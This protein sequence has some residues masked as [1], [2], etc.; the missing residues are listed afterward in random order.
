MAEKITTEDVEKIAQ[1]A[2]L[3]LS[4][5][6]IKQSTEDLQNV[7]ASF[8][9]IQNIKTGD[10]ATTDNASGLKNV[11]RED[12]AEPERLAKHEE[13]MERVPETK[14]GQIKVKNVFK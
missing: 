3:G 6:E 2:R 11:L 9:E 4:S 1:L 14:D 10:V 5:K 7:L 8:S 13:L 12:E